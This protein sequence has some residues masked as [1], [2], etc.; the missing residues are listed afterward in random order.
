M[1]GWIKLHRK[2]LDNPVVNK[3]AEHLAVWIYLLL[4]ATH[5][6]IQ[7]NCNGEFIILKKGQLITG[8]K[9]IAKE[10][11]INESKVQR[12]LNCFKS[13]HLIEQQTNPRNRLITIVKWNDYQESEQANEQQMNNKR[14]LTR[15]KESNLF[16]F[17]K[18]NTDFDVYENDPD[19]QDYL[20]TKGI[21]TKQDYYN[22][23]YAEQEKLSEK[24]VMG[25]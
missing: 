14:T 3:D 20:K 1:E 5:K 16:M 15:N 9:S 24:Y 21:N 8:R 23:T 25:G 18:Y 4:N 6:D 19:F 22:L 12:I 17:N 10:L 13:E 2:L 11:N 7:V